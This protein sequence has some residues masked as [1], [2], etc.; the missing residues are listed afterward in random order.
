MCSLEN[1]EILEGVIEKKVSQ[2]KAFTAFDITM[3]AKK[4]G[5]D[6]KHRF[7]KN[8]IHRIM[9]E[10]YSHYHKQLINIKGV[11]IPP[12]LYFPDGYNVNDYCS[13]Q[14]EELFEEI[15]EDEEEDKHGFSDYDIEN[16]PY[17]KSIDSRW[18]I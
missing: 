15:T 2:N 11:D 1:R 7:I 3:Q 13:M 12:F 4:L 18:G 9:E 17:I 14:R 6:E 16:S 5:M 10:D 8:T